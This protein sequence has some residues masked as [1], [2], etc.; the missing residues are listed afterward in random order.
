[1]SRIVLVDL[2]NTLVDFNSGATIALQQLH[3]DQ[4]P[5]EWSSYDF[6]SGYPP[7]VR[8]SIQRS[9]EVCGFFRGLQPIEGGGDAID[10]M[11]VD[12]ID[13]FICST[14]LTAYE[15]CVLEKYAWVE[16]HLGHRWTKRIILT[17]DKTLVHGD[18]LIDDKPQVE[19]LMVPTWEHVLFDQPYNRDIPRRRRLRKWAD[20]R[21]LFD[22]VTA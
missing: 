15:N 3:P 16:E 18:I 1:M 2:D 14:P 11:M 20:W 12:G 17:K 10:E 22:H 4:P 9:F 13:V 8:E 21:C 19:G 5:I 7:H 6:A